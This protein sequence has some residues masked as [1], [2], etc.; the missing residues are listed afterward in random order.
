MRA[1]PISVH[2][3]SRQKRC[4]FCESERQ[5][6]EAGLLDMLV[7]L[8]GVFFRT[9]LNAARTSF[10]RHLKHFYFWFC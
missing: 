9:F 5:P 10:R 6:T 4:E 2:Q 1:G 3:K 8:L 7:H